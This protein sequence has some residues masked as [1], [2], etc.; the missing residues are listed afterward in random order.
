[1][2][3]AASAVADVSGLMDIIEPVAPRVAEGGGWLWIVMLSVLALML[4]AMIF[5]LWKYKL[6]AYR[7]VKNLRNV[8][9]QIHMGELTLHESVLVFALEFRQ[10]LGIKRLR[11]EEIP[12]NFNQRDAEMWAAFIH[13]LETML[14]QPG[15]DLS[16]DKHTALYIQIEKWLWRY[17]R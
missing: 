2:N 17:G 3:A 4:G 8:K 6:P 11:A 7:L 9:Q 1:M 14:Y 10:G 16:T 13:E 5:Y 15:E 12:P